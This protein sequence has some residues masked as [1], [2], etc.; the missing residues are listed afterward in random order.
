[1]DVLN[2]VM[3]ALQPNRDGWALLSL[4]ISTTSK[5][6]NITLISIT[7]DRAKLFKFTSQVFLPHQKS[8]VSLMFSEVEKERA[9]LSNA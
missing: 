1:M 5:L 2:R 3:Y 8:R 6:N 4:Y 9:H 7:S